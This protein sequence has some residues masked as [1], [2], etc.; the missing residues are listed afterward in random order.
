ME[1]M[2]MN[3]GAKLNL[4]QWLLPADG[5]LPKKSV[6]GIV[7]IIHGMS[8]HSG[9]YARLAGKLNAE[10]FEVW[11]AD[12]RGH[13]LTAD[14]TINDPG[15][16]GH[17]GHCHDKSGF[18]RVTADID[19][20][21]R[22]IRKE[23]PTVPLFLLGHSWG[24]FIAQNYIETYCS[25]GMEPVKLAGCILSGTRGPAGIQAAAGYP[26]MT[27]LSFIMGKRK[28]SKLARA[29]ADGPYNKHFRPNRTPADW[30]SRDEAEVDAFINDPLCGQL[31][32]IGFY[33]DLAGGLNKIH[34]AEA[35]AGIP[36]DLPVFI[37]SG[38][39]DPVGGMGKSVT[40][41]VNIYRELGVSDLEFILY[42][43]ARH[44]TLNETN[45]EEVMVNLLAWLIKH[46]DKEA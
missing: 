5:L 8:E 15:K 35:L 20:I 42:P 36:A 44:E 29:M 3:D 45:R 16:G 28:G 24:S 37:F 43:D 30:L 25:A 10:G 12:Q 34:Q 32:S 18:D 41:L 26:L 9:R 2:P 33:R 6:R 14:K 39:A 38:S 13:G 11:A 46:T 40:D 19:Q 27:F 23:N 31:C 7:H 17:L 22:R 1:L 21:N 4:R